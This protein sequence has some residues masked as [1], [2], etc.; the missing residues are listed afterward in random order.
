MKLIGEGEYNLNALKQI[1]VT[2]DF[3]GMDQDVRQCQNER[4]TSDELAVRPG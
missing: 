3:L 2:D 1:K 4:Y